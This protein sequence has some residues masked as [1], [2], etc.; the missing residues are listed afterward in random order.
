M[1]L[2]FYDFSQLFHVLRDGKAANPVMMF[3][4]ASREAKCR[5]SVSPSYT[6]MTDSLGRVE[7]SPQFY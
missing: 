5:K 7:C 3:K 2:R 4:E 6:G 1:L